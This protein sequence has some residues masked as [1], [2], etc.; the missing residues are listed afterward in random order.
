MVGHKK[1]FLRKTV[2]F[3]FFVML[4]LAGGVHESAAIQTTLERSAYTR[5]SSSSGI[6]AFLSMLSD[7]HPSAEKVTI[8]VSAL[9]NPVEA[10]L[11][12]SDRDWIR[13][14]KGGEDK[15]TV[16]LVGSQHGKE[17]SGA[18]ALLLV[19]RDILEG[20][21]LSHIEDMHFLFIPNA[22]PDG[23][24]LKRRRNGNGVNL[25]RNYTIL[26]EPESRGILNALHR[27]KPHVVLD[28]H[29]S[30]ALKK[31]SLG[32]QG[33]LTEFEA[34][35]EAANNPNVNRDIRH[36]SFME[37]L[38]EILRQVNARGLAAQ[39][40]IKEIGSIHEPVAH[41]SLSLELLRNRA[42]IMGA[43]SF[44]LENRFDP[45]TGTYPTPRNIRARVSKQYLSIKTFL[46][47]SGA[48]RYEIMT[49]SRNA[50]WGWKNPKDNEP[51][52][53]SFG[54]F[55]DPNALEIKLP[56]RRID[57]GRPTRR[58]FRY[59]GAVESG[60]PLALSHSYVINGHQRL[61]QDILTRHHIRYRRLER[62]TEAVVPR[63][64]VNDR[65]SAMGRLGKG[66]LE[67]S[68]QE[69]TTDYLCRPG[70]L[71][72]DLNQPAQR[73]I[74]LL[75]EF[76]SDDN[77]FSNDDYIYLVENQKDF[78]VLPIRRLTQNE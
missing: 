71:L 56:L 42:G 9:G 18:E 57:S 52:Y 78:L 10:L 55:A 4:H 2:G 27:W 26:S 19:A 44:L 48:R 20:N 54:Y 51:L 37:L 28:V 76:R 21:R 17:T 30:A 29:E 58:T 59:L 12:S 33:Y 8:A 34:Q 3:L 32:A 68:F 23:R 46:E 74:P 67:Y 62:I 75:L 24:N 69:R 43:F 35:F 40:Y 50:R 53:L 14:G 38:P 65:G 77:I 47:C 41:G 45:S 31:K 5:P 7:R 61:M 66:R 22:N 25:N 49:L 70:D 15:L 13:G 6:S 73:L 11:V 1:V 64:R 60:T 36:Y 39:R 16:M 63:R 72:V